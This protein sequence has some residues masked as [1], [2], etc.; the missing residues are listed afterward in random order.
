MPSFLSCMKFVC[1]DVFCI[2]LEKQ[3]LLECSMLWQFWNTCPDGFVVQWVFRAT[4]WSTEQLWEESTG[5]V[6][7]LSILANALFGKNWGCLEPTTSALNGNRSKISL[8]IHRYCQLWPVLSLS[9]SLFTNLEMCMIFLL[10]QWFALFF[11]PNQGGCCLGDLFPESVI[12]Q[13]SKIP[14]ER[15]NM[16][17]V[18]TVWLKRDY[19][20]AVLVI[21][22]PL[23]SKDIV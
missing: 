19:F 10:Q 23:C 16:Y 11:W 14:H 18:S 22:L 2:G 6:L 5:I 13:E 15:E 21:T 4:A 12:L 7:I 9:L 1:L 3:N 17:V 8:L 20:N